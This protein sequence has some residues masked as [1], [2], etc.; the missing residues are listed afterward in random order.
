MWLERPGTAVYVAATQG[1][2]GQIAKVAASV[3]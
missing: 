1:I 3:E 2:A